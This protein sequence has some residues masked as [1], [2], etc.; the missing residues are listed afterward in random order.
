ME[1]WFF[2]ESRNWLK[3]DV[4]WL[5]KRSRFELFGDGK[6]CLFWVKKLVKRWY[7]LVTKKFLFWTFRWWKIRSFLQPK[8]WWKDDIYIVF[9]SFLWCPRTWEKWFF[10]QCIKFLVSTLYKKEIVSDPLR[11]Y[12]WCMP[13]DETKETD[14]L[15]LYFL[16]NFLRLS[17]SI[18]T[19]RNFWKIF[20][21]YKSI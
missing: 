15:L 5:L 16:K 11:L 12:N 1:I 14:K 13:K 19:F 8:S 2:L 4:Y 21:F 20:V 10:A 6:Y 17:F 9:L 3:D 7:L 18:N